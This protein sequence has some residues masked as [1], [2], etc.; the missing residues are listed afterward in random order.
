MSTDTDAL[1]VTAVLCVLTSDA[2]ISRIQPTGTS[3]S[4]GS[5]AMAVIRSTTT[6]PPLTS[7]SVVVRTSLRRN[8][9]RRAVPATVSEAPQIRARSTAD[10]SGFVGYVLHEAP[11]RGQTTRDWG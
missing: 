9:L 7:R 6:A 11:G 2:T 8:D 4:G 5:A 3:A 1:S 10:T